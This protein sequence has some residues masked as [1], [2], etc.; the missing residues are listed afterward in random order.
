MAMYLN[1]VEMRAFFGEPKY[2]LRRGP[3]F[4][5]VS[6]EITILKRI[7]DTVTRR[8]GLDATPEERQAAARKLVEED[9]EMGALAKRLKELAQ[10]NDESIALGLASLDDE[11]D[12]DEAGWTREG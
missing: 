7:S 4:E 2:A 9:P 10:A 3:N 8:T 6:E 11:S 1:K 5:L 12:E